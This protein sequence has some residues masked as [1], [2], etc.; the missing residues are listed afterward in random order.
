M[1]GVTPTGRDPTAPA[2]SVS[3]SE[4]HTPPWPLNSPEFH[5]HRAQAVRQPDSVEELYDQRHKVVRELIHQ[6]RH[7]KLIEFLVSEYANNAQAQMVPA[8]ILLALMASIRVALSTYGLDDSLNDEAAVSRFAEDLLINTGKEV[9]VHQAL[10][11]S[12][13]LAMFTGEN[14]RLETLGVLFV[15]AARACLLGLA[16]DDDKREDFVQAMHASG[17]SCLRLSRTLAVDNNDVMLWLAF[18]RVRLYTHIEGDSSMSRTDTS[19]AMQFD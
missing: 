12:G 9:V 13:F 14:L 10:N 17:S 5:G 18:D 4:T 8:P 19:D 16:R 11:L 1:A 6:L 2:T 15:L 7:L 3:Y